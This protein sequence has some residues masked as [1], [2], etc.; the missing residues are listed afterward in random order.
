MPPGLCTASAG[1]QTQ[2]YTVLKG[3]RQVMC[4]C[5][6]CRARGESGCHTSQS[7]VS[8]FHMRMVPSACPAAMWDPEVLAASCVISAAAFS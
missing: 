3:A 7:P 5:H 8:E 2:H 1:A 4:A 6:V